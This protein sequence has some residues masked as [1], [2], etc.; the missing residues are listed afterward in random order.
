MTSGS[1]YTG[2]SP[3]DTVERLE[4]HWW[5]YVCV[6]AMYTSTSIS[7]VDSS[8]PNNTQTPC[9]GQMLYE[10]HWHKAPNSQWSK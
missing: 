8:F 10:A 7:H 2:S 3:T 5:H 1:S 6:P 9:I 4:L